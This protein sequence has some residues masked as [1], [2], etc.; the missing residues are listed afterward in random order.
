MKHI[1]TFLLLTA[2]LLATLAY[3]QEHTVFVV[4]ALLIANAWAVIDAKLAASSAAR[5]ANRRH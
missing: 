5:A 2:F 3:A 4:G 1:Q